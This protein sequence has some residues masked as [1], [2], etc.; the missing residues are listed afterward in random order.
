VS[1]SSDNSLPIEIRGATPEDLEWIVEYNLRLASETEN[2]RL[3]R[4]TLRKG[5]LALLQD[6]TKGRYFVA[7]HDQQVIGQLMHTREWSDWRNGDIWW[8]QSVYI[9]EA[10]RRRGVFRRL[11]EHLWN[12]AQSRSDVVGVRLYVEVE[13]LAAQETYRDMGLCQPGYF[14]MENLSKSPAVQSIAKS[15][16]PGIA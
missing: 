12:E 6:P 13:N 9:A 11:Y 10:Y 15:D 16:S 8:L 14:V 2:K 1:T 3:D 4:E 5:V 7:V